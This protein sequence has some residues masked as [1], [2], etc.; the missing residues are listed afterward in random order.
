MSKF[1][2]DKLEQN[3]KAIEREVRWFPLEGRRFGEHSPM[4][5]KIK[6]SSGG[7]EWARCWNKG[8]QAY[9]KDLSPSERRRFGENAANPLTMD[10]EAL[11]RAN[12]AAIRGSGMLAAV[13][14]VGPVVDD[15][16]KPLSPEYHD[17]FGASLP[18]EVVAKYKRRSDGM[19][20]YPLQSDPP[21]DWIASDDQI[22]RL[23]A[24]PDFVNQVANF[25]R[26]LVDEGAEGE[27]EALGN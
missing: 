17:V 22:H 6:I 25:R 3:A 7:E 18:S 26:I 11:L 9:A 23:L 15:P 27:A 21:E 19:S 2:I 5:L 13:A 4:P 24:Y 14:L 8:A 10:A 20:S 12:R 16:S 1:D